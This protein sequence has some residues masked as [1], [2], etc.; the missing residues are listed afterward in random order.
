ML[1]FDRAEFHKEIK[2]SV[3]KKVNI[4]SKWEL[5]R[6]DKIADIIKGVTYS[7]ADQS[8]S[9]TNK[10]ILAEKY[11]SKSTLAQAILKD[12]E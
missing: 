12:N 10:I 11:D 8:L 5:E 7:K 6:L 4:E 2:L 9:E 3:K 1:T